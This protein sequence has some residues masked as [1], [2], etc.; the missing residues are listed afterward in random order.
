MLSLLKEN[1]IAVVIR[2]HSAE[3]RADMH[4]LTSRT[5]RELRLL[6]ED[7]RLQIGDDL[8]LYTDAEGNLT[9]R[10]LPELLTKVDD[11]LVE[12]HHAIQELL[13]NGLLSAAEIGTDWWY[14]SGL[15]MAPRQLAEAAVR[16]VQS[17]QDDQGRKLAD[18]LARLE[19]QTRRLVADTLL[20]QIA[21]GEQAGRPLQVAWRRTGHKPAELATQTLLQHTAALAC[22]VGAVLS[23]GEESAGPAM[24]RLLYDEINRA[25]VEAYRAAMTTFPYVV[26]E[27]LIIASHDAR[28]RID[29]I[30]TQMNLYGLGIGVYPVGRSPW[31]RHPDAL[32]FIQAVFADELA[33]D[34][35]SRL[36]RS[37]LP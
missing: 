9:A 30:H 36:M 20:Q 32:N 35:G 3:A 14:L 21:L 24:Q 17:R 4:R 23:Q 10:N 5:G 25:H 29:D 19:Q 34:G 13:L 6:Y 31:P 2:Q 16:Y 8:L 26:A 7:T 11:T 1:P 22:S 37:L 27:R 12:L 28:R 18:R 15:K 33:R